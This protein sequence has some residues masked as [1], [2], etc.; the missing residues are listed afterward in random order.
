MRQRRRGR[1]RRRGGEEAEGER[2]EERAC[3][4]CSVLVWRLEDTPAA[5]PLQERYATVIDALY[6]A[7]DAE[8]AASAKPR[9]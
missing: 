3:S 6:A 8:L 2:E 7:A 5:P 9:L 1:A 4:L